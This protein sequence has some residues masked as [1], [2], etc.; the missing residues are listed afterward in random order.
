[1]LQFSGSGGW[2]TDEPTTGEPKFP[3]P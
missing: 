2:R 3:R 1:V